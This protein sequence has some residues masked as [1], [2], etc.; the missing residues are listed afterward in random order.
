M[1]RIGEN[2]HPKMFT[3]SRWLS[4]TSVMKEAMMLQDV[5]RPF[6][7]EGLGTLQYGKFRYI[8]YRYMGP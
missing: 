5:K 4:K 8:T 7:T 1:S 2:G 6:N 3:F